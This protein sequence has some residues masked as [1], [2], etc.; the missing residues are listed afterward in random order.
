M[1]QSHH[2]F[3]DN[4][5][6]HRAVFQAVQTHTTHVFRY[7]M[8]AGT[9]PM[10]SHEYHGHMVFLGHGFDD[11]FWRAELHQLDRLWACCSGYV[12]L[13]VQ[14]VPEFIHT[15]NDSGFF[16]VSIKV[17]FPGNQSGRRRFDDMQYSDS[18]LTSNNQINKAPLQ[19]VLTTFGEVKGK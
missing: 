14:Q 16:F 3:L 1:F 18:V 8:I 5:N 9:A 7:L 11:G 2:R 19:G 4:Y 13:F 6:G 17:S 10:I 15:F 12:I